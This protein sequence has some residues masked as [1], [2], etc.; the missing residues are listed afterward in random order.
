[1]TQKVAFIVQRY[2]EEITGGSE[3]H[4]RMVAEYMTRHWQ[5]EV[6]TTCAKDYVSWQ[7]HYPAGTEQLNGVTVRRFPVTITRK[8]WL[9]DRC[10]DLLA[11]INQPSKPRRF[12]RL[13][14]PLLRL[15]A[16]A[17][18]KLTAALGTKPLL[19]RVWMVL[20]GPHCPT[21]TQHLRT[22]SYDAV[23]GF[24][25][26]Y[27]T[28]YFGVIDGLK[29]STALKVLVPTAHDDPALQFGIFDE[30]FEGVDVILANTEEERQLLQRRFPTL[31]AG[32]GSSSGPSSGSD[33]KTIAPKIQ[34][35]GCGI[36]L[37]PVAEQ[38]DVTEVEAFKARHGIERPYAVYVGRIEAF[39]GCAD[40][41]AQFSSDKQGELALVLVGKA[42][43]PIPSREDTGGTIISLGYVSDRDKEL[44]I[45]GSEFLVMPSPYESLSLVLLEAWH[46]GKPVLVNGACAV[47]KGQCQRSGGGLWFDSWQ[48]FTPQLSKLRHQLSTQALLS[49][50]LHPYPP[51]KLRDFVAKNYSWEAIG[52]KYR[53]LLPKVKRSKN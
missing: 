20:Q 46:L 28:C 43:M 13:I 44:A 41:L 50:D 36:D 8:K 16:K 11:L 22:S 51:K 17:G 48:D 30:L 29:D 19:E 21:L 25:Y 2:G 14:N 34:V 10:Y 24:S 40:L 38:P 42:E 27:S 49:S 47:L 18:H 26:V 7:N 32:S 52:D 3:A 53:K 5:V 37:P 6:L 15:F 9:F 31:A 4:C 39:K 23:I 35:V 1:M 33:A 45:A 12:G